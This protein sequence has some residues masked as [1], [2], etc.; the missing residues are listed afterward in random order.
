M[1]G[2]TG[3]RDAG[4]VLPV[5]P[6]PVGASP[7]LAAVDEQT[8]RAFV[9]DWAGPAAPASVTVLDTATGTLLRTVPIGINPRAVAVDRRAGRFFVLNVVPHLGVKKLWEYLCSY[10]YLPRLQ[11]HDVLLEAIAEGL[12][13]RDYFAYAGSVSASGRYEGLIFGQPTLADSL[14]LDELSV[15]VKPDVARAQQKAD[16]EAEGSVPE[17]EPPTVRPGRELGPDTRPKGGGA[18]PPKHVLRRYH[19]SVRLDPERLVRDASRVAEEVVQH[20][21]ALR[22]AHVEVTLDIAAHMPDGA[23]EHVV[24]TVTE[25]GRTLKFTTQGFEDE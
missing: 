13:S 24:R 21:V 1:T 22:G 5:R 14:H 7:S 4:G 23:P 12:R 15:L 16:E 2:L 17:P 25:N 6:V 9:V 8:G 18:E 10:G 11:D 3:M 20:L 19:G